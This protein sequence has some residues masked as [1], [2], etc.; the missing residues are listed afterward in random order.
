MFLLKK[1][2]PRIKRMAKNQEN[3]LIYPPKELKVGE[4]SIN[5][6]G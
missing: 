2:R 6:L 5:C 1:K 4:A 3:E